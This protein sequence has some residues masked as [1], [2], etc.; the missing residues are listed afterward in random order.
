M[1]QC[2]ST[3]WWT[4]GARWFKLGQGFQAGYEVADEKDMGIRR[5]LAIG[6]VCA[7]FGA[8]AVPTF[9]LSD[10]V[11]SAVPLAPAVTVPTVTVPTVSV[12][13]PALPANPVLPQDNPVQQVVNTVGDTVN[14]TV[15]QVQ[16]IVGNPPGGGAG[17]GGNDPGGNQNGTPGT[18]A[19]S[20]TSGHVAANG[21]G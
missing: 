17:G 13:T 6:A 9:A 1:I 18:G 11:G 10:G 7:L 5:R 19:S 3:H 4:W 8:A 14:K 16:Q 21:G 2:A 15:G 20:G 12:P